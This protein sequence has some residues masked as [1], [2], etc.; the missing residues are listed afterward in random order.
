MFD[1]S[2]SPITLILIL[3]NVLI[4]GYALFVD[5]SLVD[6]LAFKPLEILRQGQYQRLFTAGFVHVSGSHLLFN[7][8]TLY[9]FGRPMEQY[10][11]GPGK[12]LLLYVGS[13]L[14][15]HALSLVLHRDTAGYAAVGAS[16]AISGVLFGY[17]LFA[18][19]QPIYLFFVPVGIPAALFAVGY[20]VL[21]MY[22]M[23]RGR[24]GGRSMTG[25]IAHEAHLGGAL[26]GLLLTILLEPRAIS[27]F[28]QELGRIGT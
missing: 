25:G 8:I 14:A 28:F 1:F 17:C 23:R 21:S 26:G 16:G 19:L 3:V 13:E 6:R 20:V 18:P 12:F 4:S 15:A 9:F 11:L 5:E 10:V 7:M 22:A 24:E 2:E 27:I